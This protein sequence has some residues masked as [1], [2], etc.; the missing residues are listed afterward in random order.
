MLTEVADRRCVEQG[1]WLWIEEEGE[2]RRMTSCRSLHEEGARGSR[3]REQQREHHLRRVVEGAANVESK[4]TSGER[5]A[6]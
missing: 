5:Q 2:R 1:W 6:L 4:V 3:E